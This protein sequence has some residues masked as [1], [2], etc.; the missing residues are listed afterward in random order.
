MKQ[1]AFV[2]V[3]ILAGL[4][5]VFLAPQWRLSAEEPP[6]RRRRGETA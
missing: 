4:A 3:T 6:R 5:V 2:P 1:T